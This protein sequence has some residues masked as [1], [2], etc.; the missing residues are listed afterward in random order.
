MVGSNQ[1]RFCKLNHSSGKARAN[2][3]GCWQECSF[4]II[5][6]RTCN[7]RKRTFFWIVLWTL[8]TIKFRTLF[9]RGTNNCI[10]ITI[11]SARAISGQGTIF[12]LG[13]RWQQRSHEYATATT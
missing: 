12:L 1:E 9:Q 13:W 4:A 7:N 10:E 6:G 2:I 3:K 8:K 11:S 5:A